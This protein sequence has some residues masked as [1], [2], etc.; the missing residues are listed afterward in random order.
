MSLDNSSGIIEQEETIT[1]LEKQAHYPVK[2]VDFLMR[3]D[4][5]FYIK[6]EL[7][8]KSFPF[9]FTDSKNN[10]PYA[11][12][13]YQ[14]DLINLNNSQ[15]SKN[16]IIN[17]IEDLS[18][19]P[20]DVEIIFDEDKNQETHV[21][22]DNYV[23]SDNCMNI[24]KNYNNNIPQ[25]KSPI[26]SL[27]K[28][29]KRVKILSEKTI[30]EPI[31]LY[32][33]KGEVLNVTPSF[34]LHFS[35]KKPKEEIAFKQ[36][37]CEN[38]VPGAQPLIENPAQQYFDVP[39]IDKTVTDKPI[40]VSPSNIN[41]IDNCTKT[42]KVCKRKKL[43]PERVATIEKK[44]KFNMRLRD[45]MESGL[46]NIRLTENEEV[47]NNYGVQE[48]VPR[49]EYTK[50]QEIEQEEKIVNSNIE[51]YSDCG[52]ESRL[53]KLENNLI[54]K[55]EK[56]SQQIDQ[57]KNILTANFEK[58]VNSKCTQTKELSEEVKKKQLFNE[59]SVYLSVELTG[60]LYEE[61]FINKHGKNANKQ[62]NIVF[63]Q[64][65]KRKKC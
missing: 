60:L 12:E 14:T 41:P 24:N 10:M 63:P 8:D 36:E 2:Y 19:I 54:S 44:R 20:T 32:N 4:Y 43:A 45:F 52:L 53:Q 7:V 1:K 64:N 5:D 31:S 58:K 3:T 46:N 42:F 50:G 28:K 39:I 27:D 33:S 17:Q 34:I 23:N 61:L 22:K 6:N 55:I 29:S 59:L 11:N 57:L 37:E 62:V 51:K 26:K 48:R 35:N 25:K 56:N 47:L 49:P 16:N 13:N 38:Q 15:E 18:K 40:S 30:S 21:K 65:T 9:E